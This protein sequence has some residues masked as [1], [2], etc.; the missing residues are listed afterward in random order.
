VGKISSKSAMISALGA[1][2]LIFSNTKKSYGR[3]NIP[4]LI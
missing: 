3:N 2:G 4:E 1:K